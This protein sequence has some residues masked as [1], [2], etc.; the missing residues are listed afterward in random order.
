ME[1]RLQRFVGRGL[2]N[3]A[4]LR[5][6]TKA[7]EKGWRLIKK[8]WPDFLLYK[9]DEE[10]GALIRLICVEVKQSWKDTPQVHQI[11]MMHILET[12]GIKC[13]IWSMEN[14][15]LRRV[16]RKN[17]IQAGLIRYHDGEIQE[18]DLHPKLATKEDGYSAAQA[19][20]LA[21]KHDRDVAKS[22]AK[23]P[24]YSKK[25]QKIIKNFDR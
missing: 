15:A 5:F 17:I 9:T 18:D 6:A 14:N 13:F 22:W 16:G 21:R 12:L 3:K 25:W 1:E 11:K 8:G 4:E 19:R 23:Y 10:T 24:R 20:I 2:K 7:K